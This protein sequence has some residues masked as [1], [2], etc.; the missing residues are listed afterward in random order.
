MVTALFKSSPHGR[1]VIWLSH[2]ETRRHGMLSR[3]T[4][5][6]QQ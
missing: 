6:R 1:R 2:K 3:A 5:Q 4:P